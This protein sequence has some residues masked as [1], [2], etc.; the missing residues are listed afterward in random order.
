MPFAG[1][2]VF[3]RENVMTNNTV[4]TSVSLIAVLCVLSAAVLAQG[5]SS[6]DKQYNAS[7]ER[8]DTDMKKGM[9]PDPTK[10]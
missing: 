7:M 2:V 6:A 8:M 9:D 1:S 4:R 10:G 3:Q 5:Q